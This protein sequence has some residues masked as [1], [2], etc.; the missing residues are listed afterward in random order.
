MYV[1]IFFYLEKAMFSSRTPYLQM[2]ALAGNKN[3]P[4]DAFLNQREGQIDPLFLQPV[5]QELI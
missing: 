2:P 5:F 3:G 1:C 4:G